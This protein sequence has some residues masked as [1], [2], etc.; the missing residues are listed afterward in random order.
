MPTQP[1]LPPRLT[2]KACTHSTGRCLPELQLL[3]LL[4][5]AELFSHCVNLHL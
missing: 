2:P 3:R 4:A 1:T 5:A